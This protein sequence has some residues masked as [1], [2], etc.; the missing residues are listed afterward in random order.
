MAQRKDNERL[1]QLTVTNRAFRCIP[2]IVFAELLNFGE[3]LIVQLNQGNLMTLKIQSLSKLSSVVAGT[4][5]AA[6]VM[7]SPLV[8]SAE[9]HGA[10]HGETKKAEE[11]KCAEGDKACA[12]KA[13]A[14]HKDA[15]GDHDHDHAHGEKKGKY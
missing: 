5:V 6:V 9:D 14:A 4:F 1:L 10:G 7:A 8:A 11:K 12:E 2:Y 13:K 3:R 15:H